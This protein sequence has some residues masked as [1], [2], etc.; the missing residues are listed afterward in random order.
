MDVKLFSMSKIENRKKEMATVT[1]LLSSMIEQNDEVF[2]QTMLSLVGEI[3]GFLG[4]FLGF[5][6]LDLKNLEAKITELFNHKN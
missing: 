1:F 2:H 4:L 6:L 3:G 5:S